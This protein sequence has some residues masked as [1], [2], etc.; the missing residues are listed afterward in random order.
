MC[1][2]GNVLDAHLLSKPHGNRVD[3]SGES[4]LQ[5]NRVAAEMSVGVGRR[6][7]CHLMLFSVVHIHAD[8]FVAALVTWRKTLVHGFCVNEELER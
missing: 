5:G 3:A 6:P 2:L 8:V 1:R 4:S 7:C